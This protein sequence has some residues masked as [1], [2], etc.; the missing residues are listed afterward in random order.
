MKR[1]ELEKFVEKRIKITFDGESLEEES[2]TGTLRSITDEGV[3]MMRL[4][5]GILNG[6]TGKLSDIQEV[7]EL[8]D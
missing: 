4:D 7:E 8:P 3:I 6:L 1:E 5:N 2:A